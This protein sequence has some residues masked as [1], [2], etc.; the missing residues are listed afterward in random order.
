MLSKQIPRIATESQADCETENV[1]CGGT[2]N[3]D[4]QP[5]LQYWRGILTFRARTDVCRT[6]F[7]RQN[8]SSRNQYCDRPLLVSPDQPRSPIHIGDAK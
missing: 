5:K 3:P 4:T 2:N 6:T 1:L 7:Q 8:Q